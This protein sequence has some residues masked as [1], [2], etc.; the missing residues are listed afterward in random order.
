[1]RQILP[2]AL[3]FAA[4]ACSEYTIDG[5]ATDPSTFDTGEAFDPPDDTDSAADTDTGGD[6]VTDTADTGDTVDTAISDDPCTW[7]NWVPD[8][9]CAGGW[10]GTGADGNATLDG[11][12]TEVSTTLSADAAGAHFAVADATGFAV[13][14]EIFVHARDGSVAFR[15]VIAVGAGLDVD[16]AVTAPAGTTVQR[17]AHYRNVTVGT[18]G[19]RRVVFRACGTVDVGGR[20]AADA[21][22]WAGGQRTLAT[23]EVGWQG[24][25]DAGAG[26]QSDAANGTAGGGGAESCNV[27]ADGGGG[28]HGSA[29]AKGGDWDAYPCGGPGGQGGGTVGD[30]ALAALHF[31]GG[32]GSGYLDNDASAGSFGG[33]GGAGGGVLYAMASGGFSGAGMV[34]AD[35]G[36]GEDGVYFGSASPGG[37]GGGAGGSVHLLGTV[38]VSVSAIGGGGGTGSEAGGGPTVGGVGGDGRIR[39]DGILTGVATPSAFVDCP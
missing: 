17:V 15:R 8:E 2:F 1:M 5:K 34:S 19:G 37:G 10:P 24:E 9:G 22:G 36:R 33:A 31:G 16:R 23:P 3:C 32:G 28:G 27:H 7:A 21:G 30:S 29:G 39:V 25:T 6:T 35:G 12:W 38:G 4:T 18:V 13:D 26:G 11:A 20:L 14:D